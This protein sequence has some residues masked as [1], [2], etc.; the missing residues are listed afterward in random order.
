MN[1]WGGTAIEDMCGDCDYT[2][3]NDCTQDCAENWGGDLEIDA[4]DE[5]GGDNPTSC[6]PDGSG[7]ITGDQCEADYCDICNECGGDNA[8]FCYVDGTSCT[9]ATDCESDSCDLCDKCGSE[10]S[11]V[12]KFSSITSFDNDILPLYPT[13]IDIVFSIPLHGTSTGAVS[14]SS[15]L[16]N[17]NMESE[18]TLQG[19]NTLQI[20]CWYCPDL[21]S[22]KLHLYWYHVMVWKIQYQ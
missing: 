4:C 22:Q 8:V 18:I 5:W 1:E 13:P 9:F 20:T 12:P 3:V 16:D 17:T 6:S 11:C 14:V 21:S 15:S 10:N 7:C 2:E 19:G